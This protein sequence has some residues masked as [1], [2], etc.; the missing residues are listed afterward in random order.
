MYEWIARCPE[1]VVNPLGV[2]VVE[3]HGERTSPGGRL[4]LDTSGNP[5]YQ[6]KLKYFSKCLGFRSR[7]IL[8]SVELTATMFAWLES[9][10]LQDRSIPGDDRRN[11][12]EV[13]VYTTISSFLYKFSGIFITKT[14]IYQNNS[15]RVYEVKTYTGIIKLVV[16]LFTFY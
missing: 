14:V 6:N 4:E 3:P 1:T 9:L 7:Q 5:L 15:C 11:E 8:Q 10:V 16:T 12:F 2:L 13:V